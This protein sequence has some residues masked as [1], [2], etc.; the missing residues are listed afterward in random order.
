MHYVRV[1]GNVKHEWAL[2]IG[3]TAFYIFK[4]VEF[5]I[6]PFG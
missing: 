5:E 1:F 6:P 2:G 4:I 3:F